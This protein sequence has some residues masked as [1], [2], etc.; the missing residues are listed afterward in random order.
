[1]LRYVGQRLALAIPNLFLISVVV[2]VIMHVLPGDPVKTML[3]GTPVS[4]EQVEQLRAEL[5]LN[6][7]LYVQ[8]L[9]FITGALH[10]D[11]GRSLITKRTVSSEIASQFPATLI[12]TTAGM[13]I[14]LMIGLVSGVIAATRQG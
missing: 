2:F 13:G 5:G 12:L 11:L 1:M 9:D 6:R 4:G 7:P 3:A 10:G 8:Y 14:A